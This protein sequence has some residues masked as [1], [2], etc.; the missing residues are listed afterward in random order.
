MGYV[1]YAGLARRWNRYA[2]IAAGVVA[3]ERL[4]FAGNGFRCPLTRIAER[5]GAARGSVTDI[6]MPQW[7]ARNL[8]AHPRPADRPGRIPPCHVMLDLCGR[9]GPVEVARRSPQ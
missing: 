1:L 9:P 5:L 2:A 3:A 8:P 4:N 6:Y 7:F